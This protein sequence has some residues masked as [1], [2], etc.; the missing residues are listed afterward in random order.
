MQAKNPIAL[1]ADYDISRCNAMGYKEK[2]SMTGEYRMNDVLVSVV[3][4]VYNVEKYLDRCITSILKQSLK[5]IELI[6]VDD[7]STDE[8]GAICDT[9]AASDDRVSVYHLSNGGPAKARN[10]GISVAKGKYIGFVDSDDEIDSIMYQKMYENAAANNSNIVI[11][12]FGII[13]GKAKTTQHFDFRE[14]YANKEMIKKELISSYFNGGLPGLSSSCNKIFDLSMIK[15]ASLLM[16]EKLIRGED[17]FFVLDCLIASECV[18]YIAEPL[19]LYYQ[20]DT[21]IMHSF[22]E[23]NYDRHVYV[24]KKLL[25]YSENLHYEIEPNAFYKGFLHPVT[26][27]CMEATR[28]GKIDEVKR[29]LND[30]FYR[31]AS[32]Y[33]K[34]LPVHIKLLVGLARIGWIHTAILVYKIWAKIA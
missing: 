24:V 28:L 19:Y 15:K 7:G 30:P 9:Y 14:L 1:S 8:S 16:D 21:S 11:C 5:N 20:N 6:L 26:A 27:H 23:N 2:E 32:Q 10:Y 33:T 18:S 25:G 4:P 3:V 34:K 29:I 17:A 13:N 12:D 22:Q 31:S